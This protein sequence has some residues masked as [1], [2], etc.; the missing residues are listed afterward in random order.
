MGP[1]VAQ[2]LDGAVDHRA[3]LIL[4]A[5]RTFADDLA[6]L[7]RHNMVLSRNFENAGK[8]CGRD[9]NDGAGTAFAEENRFGGQRRILNSYYRAEM[10]RSV[11]RLY[12]RRL[13]SETGLGEGDG[14]AAVGNVVR[15]L[16]GAFGGERYEAV[17]KTFL[18]R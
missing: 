16:D 4:D 6:E 11:P 17:L 3:P 12:K 18:G 10:G 5:E 1:G 2:C 14:E 15:G 13:G 8:F 9:G 7:S